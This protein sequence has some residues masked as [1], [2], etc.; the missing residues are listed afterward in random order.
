MKKLR[1]LILSN[2]LVSIKTITR[3]PFTFNL[4]NLFYQPIMDEKIRTWPLPFLSKEHPNLEKALIDWP[5][6]LQYD[7]KAKYRLIS[8]QFLGMKFFSPKRLHNQPKAK[9]I[10]ICSIN[11]SN[12]SISIRLLCLF[13]SR[14][15]ISRT[16]ENRSFRVK[17]KASK[18]LRE[19]VKASMRRYR[20]IFVN[21]LVCCLT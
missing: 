1:P 3:T 10:C 13:C 11:Q 2:D 6:M 12:Y 21:Q 17:E 5:I 7:I 16:F 4:S 8:R 20:R 15:F 18:W 19:K 9:R 14:I